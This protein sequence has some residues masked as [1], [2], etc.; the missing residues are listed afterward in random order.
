MGIDRLDL[1][2]NSYLLQM[3]TTGHHSIS[4]LAKA[5]QTSNLASLQT[6]PQHLHPLEWSD[7]PPPK[8]GK[9]IYIYIYIYTYLYV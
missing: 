6:I 8:K 1:E 3:S 2:T 4:C 7:P 9:K 5:T